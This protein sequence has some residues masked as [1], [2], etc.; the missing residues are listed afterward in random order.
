MRHQP[1]FTNLGYARG[2]KKEQNR[3]VSDRD[4]EQRGKESDSY[5]IGPDSELHPGLKLTDFIEN[6]P[7]LGEES[8][9]QIPKY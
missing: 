4:G 1:L 7:K 9:S 5:H 3:C 8:M 2:G 6:L